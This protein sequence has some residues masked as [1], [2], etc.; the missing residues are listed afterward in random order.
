MNGYQRIYHELEPVFSEESRILILGSLP[1][2][3]SRETGFYYGH[4]KNRFWRV[5][6]TVFEEPLPE[7]IEQKRELILRHRLALWD[8]IES[9]LIKGAS[10]SSIKEPVANDIPKLLERTGISHIVTTGRKAQSLYMKLVYPR[11]GIEAI[12]LPSTSPANCAVGEEEL[13]SC[14]GILREL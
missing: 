5:I 2:P 13:I 4:P 12:C 11:T 7:T 9:C 6:S 14:Y 8:V 3:K 1:S 10:D